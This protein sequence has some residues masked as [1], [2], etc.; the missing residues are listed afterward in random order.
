MANEYSVEIH[1]Y[2]SEQMAVAE[3]RRQKAEADDDVPSRFYFEG[4]L[5]ELLKIREYMAAHIDLKTQ[6][7]Y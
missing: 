4:R 6:K 7:Y 1:Q 2:I 5:H 3:K